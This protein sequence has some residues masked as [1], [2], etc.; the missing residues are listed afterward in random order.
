MSLA[1]DNSTI[2]SDITNI[3]WSGDI[4]F[5]SFN[6]I[7]RPGLA[8]ELVD[9]DLQTVRS[10]RNSCSKTDCNPE[11]S[12]TEKPR[13]NAQRISHKIREMA[14]D[15]HFNTVLRTAFEEV[16]FLLDC[17]NMG[18]EITVDVEEDKE[19]P[20]WKE[21]VLSIR[22]F[23]V[24]EEKTF[25]IWEIIE[26]NI[27]SRINRMGNENITEKYENLVITVNNFE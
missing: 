2:Q 8:N 18:Y 25:Q 17:E 16:S 27:Q 9:W 13:A 4:S 22:L 7:L 3:N 23:N 14:K 24:S 20:E 6:S 5:N 1:M 11:F 19:I 10:Q 15:Q 26:D 12:I 21:T